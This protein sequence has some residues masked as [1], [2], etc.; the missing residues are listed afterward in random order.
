MPVG[1]AG[2]SGEDVTE[3]GVRIDPTTAAAF[4]D[5]V[6]DG[7]AF[8][9]LGLPDEQPVLLAEGGGADGVFDQ[10]LVDLDA[11]VIEG[12]KGVNARSWTVSRRRPERK[13]PRCSRSSR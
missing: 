8:P 4:D 6:E 3:V 9:G 2:Q 10:V 11:S 12:G 13:M 1:G 5:G 7:A